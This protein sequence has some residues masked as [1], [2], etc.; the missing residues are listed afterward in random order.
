M[1]ITQEQKSILK[2]LLP[3]DF[4]TIIAKDDVF[5]LLDALDDLYLELLDED[6]EPTAESEECERLRDAIH[7]Q[8][9]HKD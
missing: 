4:E 8:N 9:V 3:D 2:R 1:I 5:E 6:Q 7:F